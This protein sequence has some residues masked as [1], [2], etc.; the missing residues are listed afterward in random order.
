MTHNQNRSHRIFMALPI[1]NISDS[2]LNVNDELKQFQNILKLVPPEN[3]HITL[4]FIGNT[5]ENDFCR[6]VSDFKNFTVPFK[7][8]PFTLTGLGSFPKINRANVL[9][10]GIKCNTEPLLHLKGEI[11]KLLSKYK[12]KKDA[13][14]FKAHLTLARV[15]KNKKIP[16]ELIEY[17]EARK[18]SKYGEGHF[19]SLILFESQLTPTGPIYKEIHKLSFK[20]E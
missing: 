5:E 10:C 2:L 8:I 15:R 11:E 13:N 6:I 19:D 12:I 20:E 17:F 16:V 4:K 1:H 3:F 9:W 18:N 14:S 7:K